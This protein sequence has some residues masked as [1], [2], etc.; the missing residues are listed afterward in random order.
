MSSASRMLS[1][2]SYVS[3]LATIASASTN[4]K[5]SFIFSPSSIA[6]KPT[7]NRSIPAKRLSG[8]PVR[9]EKAVRVRGLPCLKIQILRD[10]RGGVAESTH[11]QVPPPRRTRATRRFGQGQEQKP[12]HIGYGGVVIGSNLPRLT[13]KLGFDG[14][15]DVSDG[16]HGAAL[17]RLRNFALLVVCA[18]GQ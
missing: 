4:S 14:Y 11:S 5:I 10:P 8:H 12:Y 16:S 6:A 9:K 7:G 15:G 1:L 18:K 13:V 3:V 17:Q 2:Q